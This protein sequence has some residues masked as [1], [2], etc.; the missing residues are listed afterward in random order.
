ME[1]RSPAASEARSVPGATQA[2]ADSARMPLPADT[3]DHVAAQ[4]PLA[5]PPPAPRQRRVDISVDEETGRTLV[6]LLDAETGDIVRQ[7]PAEE[8][9][10][11]ARAIGQLKH[12]RLDTT[13]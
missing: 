12:G 9:L 13:A 1:I 5:A 2:T 11:L 3:T 10:V 7:V 4:A 8:S 6:R